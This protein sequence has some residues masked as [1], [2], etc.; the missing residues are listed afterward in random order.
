MEAVVN[1]LGGEEGVR[2]FLRGDIT[3]TEPVRNWREEN[4]IIYLT[5]TSDGSTGLQWIERLKNKGFEV[6]ESAYWV[7]RSDDFV[8]TCGVTSEIAVLKGM[9]FE[10]TDRFVER[11]N[12]RADSRQLERPNAEVACLIREKFSDEEIKAMGL[13]FILVMHE[14]IE[15][16]L[17]GANR[18]SVG[19]IIYA[20]TGGLDLR[21]SR[22]FGFAFA[23]S[24]E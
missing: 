8:P 13:E 19:R 17:L 2:R 24:Q 23:V 1:K 11:I 9:L 12:V 3:V 7:L 10:N 15:H 18:N 16:R 22:D 20:Q 4:G 14:F 5:V 21:L 6:S